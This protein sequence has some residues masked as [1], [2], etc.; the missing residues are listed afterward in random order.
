[1]NPLKRRLIATVLK[2]AGD[3]GSW[4]VLILSDAKVRA[5]KLTASIGVAFGPIRTSRDPSHARAV[6][7]RVDP[8]E[9]IDID[10]AARQICLKVDTARRLHPQGIGELYRDAH[11]SF[12]KADDVSNASV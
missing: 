11:A 1:M 8:R 4:K 9:A 2:N 7:I 5:P 3:S 6:E 10:P 12:A